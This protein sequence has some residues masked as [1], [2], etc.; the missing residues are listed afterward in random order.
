MGHYETFWEVDLQ[1]PDTNQMPETTIRL[2]INASW[3]GTMGYFKTLLFSYTI[4][5]LKLFTI[6]KRTRFKIAFCRRRSIICGLLRYID[7]NIPVT[8]ICTDDQW[9]LQLLFSW[10]RAGCVIA[11]IMALKYIRSNNDYSV[12]QHHYGF[13]VLYIINSTLHARIIMILKCFEI[14]ALIIL[15]SFAFC[16][17]LPTILWPSQMHRWLKIPVTGVWPVT[18]SSD[19]CLL[20]F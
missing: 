20:C 3:S 15:R 13:K 11:S 4:I 5:I 1:I 9:N 18:I 12:L 7:L 16:T 19:E 6:N 2:H 10:H 14:N 8:G 17:K